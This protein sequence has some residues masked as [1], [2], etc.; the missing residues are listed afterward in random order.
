MRARIACL[1]GIGDSRYREFFRQY[2]RECG[3]VKFYDV[4]EDLLSETGRGFDLIISGI[5]CNLGE[6]YKGREPGLT[7]IYLYDDLKNK[8]ETMDTP[9]LLFHP[10]KGSSRALEEI[11]KRSIPS[12]VSLDGWKELHETAL[13]LLE[14]NPV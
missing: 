10:A 3:S 6:V 2:L 12:I 13:R 11:D 9:F 8:P 1:P 7:G 5:N 4:P 14:G